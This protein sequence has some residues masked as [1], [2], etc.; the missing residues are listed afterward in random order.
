MYVG[1]SMT[2]CKKP[3]KHKRR[4]WDEGQKKVWHPET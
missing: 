3:T 4:D 1:S 2:H